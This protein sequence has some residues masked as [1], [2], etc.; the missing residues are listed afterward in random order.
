MAHLLPR[1]LFVVLGA[2]S[3]FGPLSMDLYLPALPQVS[4]GLHS[5]EA[6]AQLTLSAC[7]VGLALG[8]LVLGPVSDRYGRRTPLLIGVGAY[9][10][11]S[12]ACAFATDISLLITLRLL[13]GMAGG[14]GIVIARAVV[15]DLCDTAT[16]ARVF[17]LLM[18]VTGVAPIIAPLLGGQLL[19]FTHWQGTFVAL[20]LVGCALL[21]AALWAVPESLPP[22]RRTRA[23]I[24]ESTHELATVLR[25]R[26]FFGFTAVL[27]LGSGMLFCYIQM[28]PFVFQG[29]YGLS[30]QSFSLVFAANSAGIILGG[31][32]SASLVRRFGPGTTLTIGL[33]AGLA[34]AVTLATSAALHMGL[35][36]LLP[37]LF[38]T[39][40]SVS[41]I[42]PTSTALALS[43]HQ[44]RAGAASGLLGL[45]QFGIGG[46][47]APLISA[48]GATAVLMTASM[49]GAV[50]GA[51]VA[52][53][54]V[55]W[56][57][58]VT[59]GSQQDRGRDDGDPKDSSL[60]LG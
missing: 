19:R 50:L 44:S 12:L 32:L 31:P 51:L 36:V 54:L 6:V 57:G 23:G 3:A 16:A 58:P 38:V 39:V 46:I 7:M 60:V 43:A 13:Q 40:S 18:L 28:S 37:L 53:L 15:R 33:T 52:R 5:T 55:A 21:A 27:A 11:T 30:A 17:S 25:D 41:L 29:E 49:A 9:A 24:R 48:G 22:Q 56:L 47:I 42:M 26:R 14:A 59:P 1:R 45:A 20:A 8:Q 35:A 10:V 4:A 34:S 2:L